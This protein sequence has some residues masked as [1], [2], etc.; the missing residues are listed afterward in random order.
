MTQISFRAEIDEYTNRV[1]GVVKEKYG[2]KTKS[3]ALNL[4]ADMYGEEFVDR[5]IKDELIQEMKKISEEHKKKYSNRA[6]TLEELDKLT[7]VKNVR[8]RDRR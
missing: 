7:G 5:E 8:I 6:M 4:F 2:L 3:E 1:L